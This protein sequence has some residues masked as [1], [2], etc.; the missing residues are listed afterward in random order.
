MYHTRLIPATQLL[1]QSGLPQGLEALLLLMSH[2]LSMSPLASSLPHVRWTAAGEVEVRARDGVKVGDCLFVW[3]R[4]FL[5]PLPCAATGQSRSPCTGSRTRHCMRTFVVMPPP[6]VIS[7]LLGPLRLRLPPTL[8]TLMSGT[9]MNLVC[10]SLLLRM[11]PRSLM[12]PTIPRLLL[13]HIRV[14]DPFSVT[15][16]HPAPVTFSLL[17]TQ[18]RDP[19]LVTRGLLAPVTTTILLL[20]LIRV[21][22][23]HPGFPLA[24][25]II[26]RRHDANFFPGLPFLPSILSS[27]GRVLIHVLSLSPRFWSLLPK[28]GRKS[29]I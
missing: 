29:K 20:L 4:A 2:L 3:P 10:H 12:T 7:C 28:R 8:R 11:M 6:W 14:R 13:L 27:S 25:L 26:R 18:V 15:P 22:L 16:D 9:N 19:F 1:V 21:R 17:S 23:P 24:G 5:A